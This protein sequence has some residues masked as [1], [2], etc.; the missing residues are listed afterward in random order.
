MLIYI[1]IGKSERK[2]PLGINRLIWKHNIK[3]YC[4]LPVMAACG[5]AGSDLCLEC[6]GNMLLRDVGNH[7]HGI[8]P[9]KIKIQSS[10]IP[11]SKY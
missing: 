10:H 6:G 3:M 11:T 7:L 9:N 5:I 8:K 1:L 2:R 4:S